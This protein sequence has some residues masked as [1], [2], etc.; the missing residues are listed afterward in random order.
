MAQQLGISLKRFRGWEPVTHYTYELGKLVSSVPDV[1][2]DDQEHGWMV[3]LA[4]YRDTRCP[5]CNGDL[6]TTTASENEDCFVHEPPLVCFKCVAFSRVHELYAD[7]PH[8]QSL[9]YLV[10]SRGVKPVDP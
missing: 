8:P 5:R 10:K 3:A 7:E 2:W 4:Q 6:V 9:I 1:E